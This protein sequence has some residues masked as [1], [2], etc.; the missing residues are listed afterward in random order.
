MLA[1]LTSHAAEQMA[2]VQ[3]NPSTSSCRASFSSPRFGFKAA[4]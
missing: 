2:T 3:A 4:I 1:E